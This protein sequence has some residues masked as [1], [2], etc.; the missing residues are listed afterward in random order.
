MYCAETAVILSVLTLFN[1]EFIGLHIWI[2]IFNLSYLQYRDI[3]YSNFHHNTSVIQMCVLLMIPD[4]KNKLSS[5][6]CQEGWKI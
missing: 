6:K 4:T 3:N 2:Y 1:T 5:K